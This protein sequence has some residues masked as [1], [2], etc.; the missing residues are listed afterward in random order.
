MYVSINSVSSFSG[1][2]NIKFNKQNLASVKACKYSDK[3]QKSYKEFSDYLYKEEFQTLKGCINAFCL[4]MKTLYHKI[5]SK[6]YNP[7][8]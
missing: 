8:K 5:L 1:C 4:G 6:Y 2:N 3:Y 7:I